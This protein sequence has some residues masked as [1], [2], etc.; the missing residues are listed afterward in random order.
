MN[1][2]DLMIAMGGAGAAA[3]LT[4]ARAFAGEASADGP[5]DVAGMARD[6]W[7]YGLPIIEMATTR[8]KHMGAGAPANFFFGG[9][10][11]ATPA[12]RTVTNPNN[13]T[14]Y[15][16][17]WLDL[18]QGPVTLTIPDIKDRYWSLAVM[19]MYSN[20]NVVLGSRTVGP[21][22]GT[23]TLVGP[24]QPLSGPN[25]VRIATPHAWALAR[26]LVD[27]PQDV[28]EA[29]G[30]LKGFKLAGKAG[31]RPEAFAGRAADPAD[32]FDSVRRL[33]RAN[34]PPATDLAILRRCAPLLV[35]GTAVDPAA[36][37]AGVAEARAL[38]RN[39]WARDGGKDGWTYP[40][41][42]LGDYGQDYGYR[43]AVA[44]GGLAALPRAEAIYLRSRGE[45]DGLYVSDRTWRLS[46]PADVPVDA[47]WS[48]SMYEATDDGHFFFTENPLNRYAI[49]D[50]TRGL[51]RRPDG[52]VDIWISRTDPGGTRSA[53]WLPAPKAGPWIVTWRAYRPKAE[54]I[55]GGWKLPP[56]VAV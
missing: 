10:G 17:A 20:N 14:L 24:D 19:D 5:A 25:P 45:Q 4:G 12:D 28:D 3:L 39:G 35:D 56:M 13:D 54:L 51:T 44:L 52:G 7:I 1:R 49:G 32:Y 15:L 16:V 22:G 38:I 36:V 29:K 27:G 55:N 6:A 50:R 48:L 41:F 21:V 46:M 42:N 30:L 33:M 2:R 47:F 53:N 9:R 18:T 11:L 34:P 26:V 43:A 37:A 31:P 23:F 8:A 40:R